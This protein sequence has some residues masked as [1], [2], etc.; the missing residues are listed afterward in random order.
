MIRLAS[1]CAA[2]LNLNVLYNSS[3]RLQVH[4]RAAARP[5]TRPACHCSVVLVVL[6]LVEG[7]LNG[8]ATHGF[9]RQGAQSGSGWL[10]VV[11]VLSWDSIFYQSLLCI[12][13]ACAKRWSLEAW[14]A[15][16]PCCLRLSAP[17]HQQFDPH[18][19]TF[20]N[21]SH[22]LSSRGCHSTPAGTT[23]L[24][25][26]QPSSPLSPSTGLAPG[27]RAH[28]CARACTCQ[29]CIPGSILTRP[30]KLYTLEGKSRV[31]SMLEPTSPTKRTKV[32]PPA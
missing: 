16:P 24:D 25:P 14:P 23:E 8:I 2:F 28:S 22:R 29:L 6:S 15:C 20:G 1:F 18:F 30:G 7:Y 10:C 31:P 4:V 12:G 11:R 19:K 9:H 27:L 21:L 17:P 26:P 3:V 13:P 5:R 32:P